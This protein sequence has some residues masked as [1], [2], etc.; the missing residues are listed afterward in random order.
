M[1]YIC[2]RIYSLK[3]NVSLLYRAVC[4]HQ[5]SHT[6]IEK[7][8]KY[9]M[10]ATK[11]LKLLVFFSLTSY[12]FLTLMYQRAIRIQTKI[13]YQRRYHTS[14]R[15]PESYSE[16]IYLFSHAAECVLPIYFSKLDIHRTLT[17]GDT[18]VEMREKIKGLEGWW[19]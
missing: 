16:A 12:I 7:V 18:N 11:K 6:I 2:Q 5:Q 4:V 9:N 10:N 19:W 14:V 8:D 13:V 1:L 17:N 15:T 3:S